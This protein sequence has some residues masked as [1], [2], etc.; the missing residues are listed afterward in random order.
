LTAPIERSATVNPTTAH[1]IDPIRISC[2]SST[3]V[4]PGGH[5][6]ESGPIVAV[7]WSQCPAREPIG[8]GRY[9]KDLGAKLRRGAGGTDERGTQIFG[10]CDA[11]SLYA[12]LS[13]TALEHIEGVEVMRAPDPR[14]PLVYG[15]R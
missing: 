4:P 7:R 14:E 15:L 12:L 11:A 10:R 1:T 5:Q 13:A 9:L 2:R 3:R 8:L 6:I